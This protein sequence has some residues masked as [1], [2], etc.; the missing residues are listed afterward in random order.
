MSAQ[1]KS[2]WAAVQGDAVVMRRVN[3]WL[4][5]LWLL[6][7]PVSLMTHWVSSVTGRREVVVVR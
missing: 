6:M 3:G 4:T 2:L 5:I 7:I 1:V